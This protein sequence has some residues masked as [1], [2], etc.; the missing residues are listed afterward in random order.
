MEI[1][2]DTPGNQVIHLEVEDLLE[3]GAVSDQ[4]AESS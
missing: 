2:L 1:I 3:D 4:V